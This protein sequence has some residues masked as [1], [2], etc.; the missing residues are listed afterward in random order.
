MASK[1]ITFDVDARNKIKKGV[2]TLANA[3][4]VTLGP[5]GRNVIIDKKFGAPSITKDGVTVAKEIELKDA[6][7]N[8]GAQLV[9]EVASKT[10]DMAGDGTTTATVL[11]Q[12]IY[13]A[14]SKNVAAGANPMDLKRGIDKAVHK[15]VENLKTQSKKIENSSE[16]A[17]VGTISANND[18][19]I[20][21]MIA[22]AMDKVGK[23]GVITVEE[24]KGTETEVKTVEGMQFDRGYLSPYFVTNPEK[25]EAEFENAYILIYDKKVSTMKEL[26]PVLE[27]VVQTGKALVIISE[28]V[29]GEALATLVVNKLRGSLKIAAVKAPGFGDRRKAM[30]EDIAIL[31]GGTVIS[32]ERGYKLDNATLDYLGQAE[33]IIIDKDNTTIVNGRGEKDGITA[34]VNE[35]KSQIEKTTSDYDREKLQER[36]AKLSGG[37]AILYIGASTEVEMK[38]K[39]DRVDDALHATRAA[40]E[41]GIVAGG[42]VALIR[43]IDALNDVDT[44]NEDEKTGVQIIRTALESPLRTIVANAGGEGS[45]IVNEVRAGKADFGYNARDDKFENMFAAGIIDPTKVTRL[46]LENAASVASLLLTTECVIADEPEEGGAAAGGGMPGGMGGMG[47]M[48]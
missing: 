45:V 1:N 5:K 10:A 3:V 37:V 28:D 11:A 18:S 43:A 47:G 13:T 41:E 42:G 15:V 22:D 9:K 44:R 32:E 38:E 2:D 7:E 33:R 14:G 36:L 12:A 30:L 48:M 4:K 21:Q 39:K 31:T 26:L 24:A 20:G 17:Q 16:I 27:Q 8:M 40:V 29:D 19:E 35:I 25:M 6:V 23:D 46:A 34:R